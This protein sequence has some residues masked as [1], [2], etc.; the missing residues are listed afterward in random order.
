MLITWMSVA[1]AYPSSNLS[2]DQIAARLVTEKLPDRPRSPEFWWMEK[3]PCPGGALGGPVPPAAR[4]V[5]CA[6]TSHHRTGP[7]TTLSGDLKVLFQTRFYRD[8]EVG[9]R[10]DWN[11]A[12]QQAVAWTT[13]AN[14]VPHG[15]SVEWT[16]SGT[17]AGWLKKGVKDGPTFKLD[18]RGA[19]AFVVYWSSGERGTRSCVWRE[20][21][22]V[23]DTP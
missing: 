19:V 20:G 12:T 6:D 21:K 5:W 17:L 22:L 16:D 18:Q 10:I 15:L 9:P 1:S 8:T 7:A 11:P 4:E 23:I 3:T 14:D 2:C 13:F